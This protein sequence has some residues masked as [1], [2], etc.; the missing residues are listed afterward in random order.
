MKVG[1]I[2]DWYAVGREVREHAR[3]NADVPK[4]EGNEYRDIIV[5][6]FEQLGAKDQAYQA[7][8]DIVYALRTAGWVV[9]QEERVELAVE[10]R[11][12]CLALMA[13][14]LGSED[15]ERA[16]RGIDHLLQRVFGADYWAEAVDSM[17]HLRRHPYPSSP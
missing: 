6:V 1:D 13:A 16:R 12:A 3:R 7:V 11:N 9:V 10:L 5:N 8:D 15:E 14:E 2:I 4:I 17:E